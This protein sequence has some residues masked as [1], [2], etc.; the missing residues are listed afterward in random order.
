MKFSATIAAA[1]LLTS[2]A[3]RVV[4]SVPQQYV[5]TNI[6][7][8]IKLIGTHLTNREDAVF[9]GDSPPPK[10]PK[11]NPPDSPTPLDEYKAAT[12]MLPVNTYFQ[13][14]LEAERKLWGYIDD[15]APDCDIE[16]EY[17]NINRA[18]EE[19]GIYD[20][21]TQCFRVSHYDSHRVDE[22]GNHIGVKDQTYKVGDKVFRATGAHGTFGINANE[23]VVFFIDVAS[24]AHKAAELWGV[25]DPPKDQLPALRQMS[26][27]S[28]GY[29]YLA[30]GGTNLGH[31]TKFIVPQV[32]NDIT[33]R[34]INAAL[35]SYV[36][37]DGEERI[38][39]VPEWPGITFDIET[40]ACKA[41]L[42]SPNGIAAAYFLSQHKEELGGNKYID[43]VTVFRPDDGTEN[44]EPAL[45]YY[46]ED[47]P[48]DSLEDTSPEDE[49][50]GS[51]GNP[52]PAAEPNEADDAFWNRHVCRGEKLHE[53]SIRNKDTA[54]N[55]VRAV[56]SEFDGTMEDEMKTWG[57]T[58]EQGRSIFCNLDDLTHEL[59]SLGIDAEFRKG[60]KQGDNE[61]FHV[62]HRRGLGRATYIKT[63][64]Y[65]HIGVNARDGVVSFLN[66]MS[67]EKAATDNWKVEKPVDFELPRLRQ[68]SD[69]TWAF[70]NR[71]HKDSVGLKDINLFLVHQI[72]NQDT[73]RLIRMAMKSYKVP[74]GEQR[75]VFVPRWP[76][77]EFFIDTAEGQAMLG[78]PNGLS[79]GYFLIQHKN[80]LGGNKYVHKV[81]VWRDYD[82]DDHM[83]LWVKDAPLPPQEAA[84]GIAN[85]SMSDKGL[86][87]TFDNAGNIVKRSIDGKNF[88]REHRVVARS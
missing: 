38:T 27:L 12:F 84:L 82:G 51:P 72:V 19:L 88:I 15:A 83:L 13:G 14:S 18:Y 61:C 34:L 76:G 56:D 74:D 9:G 37:P 5:A 43:K 25:K 73:M 60:D 79:A 24:A 65:A 48:S 62:H 81:T 6:T 78:S 45:V 20:K 71:A 31:I 28:W 47:A 3:C 21:D 75:H 63:G 35:E 26:D 42:G 7:T 80:Q 17:Y 68:I 23:G 44:D 58:D 52:T 22:N 55:F 59:N 77:I 36:V 64:A 11:P 57:Y 39:T 85:D 69:L 1:L 86:S 54:L 4:P 40:E 66:I 50:P 53:A 30:H 67:A 41:L 32:I 8:L 16:G 10:R 49:S 70:W 29:W 2:A 87:G 46:V 33:L